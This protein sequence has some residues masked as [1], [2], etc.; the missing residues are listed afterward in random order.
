MF[1][2]KKI[3]AKCLAAKKFRLKSDTAVGLTL[4]S[5]PEKSENMTDGNKKGTKNFNKN[6]FL[7]QTTQ[8]VILQTILL[9]TSDCKKSNE[10]KLIYLLPYT[11]L[12]KKLRNTLI[13]YP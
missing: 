6:N 8:K 9:Y 3:M 4:K 11:T 2:S 1:T 10:K 7:L 13:R 5:L 12:R